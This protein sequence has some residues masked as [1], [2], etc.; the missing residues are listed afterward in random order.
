MKF[1]VEVTNNQGGVLTFYVEAAGVTLSDSEVRDIAER[2]LACDFTNNGTYVTGEL[3]I[4]SI[5]I[6]DQ[7]R[8]VPVQE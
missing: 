8:S 4:F 3:E 5:D 2:L 1:H 7:T 6:L